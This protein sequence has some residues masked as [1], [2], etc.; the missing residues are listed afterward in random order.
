MS[1]AANPMKEAP[2][3]RLLAV[4][5]VRLRDVCGATQILGSICDEPPGAGASAPSSHAAAGATQHR[6]R[7]V[8]TRGPDRE[9]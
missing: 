3:S 9:P 8:S 6:R 4:G 1:R 2:A 7:F 5:A